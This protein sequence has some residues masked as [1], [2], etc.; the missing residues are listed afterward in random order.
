[1]KRRRYLA[2]SGVLSAGI[3]GCS[4]GSDEIDDP[5]DPPD[6]NS[7]SSD[8]SD[9]NSG[10]SD[11]PENTDEPTPTEPPGEPDLEFREREL[12]KDDSGYT[13]E[14]YAEVIVEN[15]GDGSAGQVTVNIEWY[16]ADGNFL[17]D[18][19]GRLP[20]LEP[21]EVWIAQVSALT[22]DPEDIESIEISGEFENTPLAYP[23]GM[24]V[25]ESELEIE[26]YSAQISGVAENTRE[27]E[28]GYVEAH[29][30]IYDGQGRVI[31]GGLTNE[32][33]IPAG[34]NWAFE[35]PLTGRS[36]ARAEDA[37]DHIAFLDADL[38]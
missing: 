3:A 27:D 12:I 35:I 11:T 5:Q 8:A 22:S 37:A 25:I 38:F 2:L 17:D 1:M 32:T 36:A 18:S 28:M 13:T 30:K 29:G 19:T 9:D 33:D 24:R 7:E 23:E 31:G 20:S 21:G 6:N 15:I 4:G 16:D 26:E 34:R 14:A 10:S